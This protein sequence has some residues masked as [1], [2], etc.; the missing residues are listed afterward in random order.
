M[1]VYGSNDGALVLPLNDCDFTDYRQKTRMQS[2]SNWRIS[3]MQ[4]GALPHFETPELFVAEYES[5]LTGLSQA[6]AAPI[7]TPPQ[8]GHPE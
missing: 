3:V 7:R 1:P 4:T 2:A 5:F 6:G 8:A